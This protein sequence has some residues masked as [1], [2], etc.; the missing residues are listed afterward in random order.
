[1]DWSWVLLNKRS[2]IRDP[3]AKKVIIILFR[4]GIVSVKCF[5]IIIYLFRP[6][7]HYESQI[8]TQNW[9]STLNIYRW[10]N[11][12][13]FQSKSQ[14]RSSKRKRCNNYMN[15]SLQQ[16]HFFSDK[17]GVICMVF[18]HELDLTVSDNN[19]SLIFYSTAQRIIGN[20][21]KKEKLIRTRANS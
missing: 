15:L 20:K 8:L 3:R 4:S 12:R 1:M 7:N 16:L 11:L 14:F 17:N 10:W 21:N 13:A 2:L 19:D 6:R 18:I 5:A 9:R